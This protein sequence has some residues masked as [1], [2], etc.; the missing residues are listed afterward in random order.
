MSDN[1]LYHDDGAPAGKALSD[2]L[3]ANSS[4]KELNVSNSAKESYSSGGPSFAKELAVGLS[5]NG[6]LTSL[7]LS[8]NDLGAEGAKHVA[9]AIKVNV[10]APQFDWYHFDFNCCCLWILLL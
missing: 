1:G 2:M 3:Q 6:A 4:L 8:E 7:N 5:A 9:E 10:S